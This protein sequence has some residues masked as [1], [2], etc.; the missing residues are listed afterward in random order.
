MSDTKW[1]K[2]DGR[3]TIEDKTSD[4]YSQL[5]KDLN[6][7]QETLARDPFR[8]HVRENI[9]LNHGHPND[10]IQT[11]RTVE[12][13]E[14]ELVISEHLRNETCSPPVYFVRETSPEPPT[15]GGSEPVD[16]PNLDQLFRNIANDQRKMKEEIST[17]R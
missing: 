4:W 10:V 17:L 6:E 7:V 2:S 11:L 1:V 9:D 14:E 8:L 15:I 5:V 16:T 3:W 13:D 12:I